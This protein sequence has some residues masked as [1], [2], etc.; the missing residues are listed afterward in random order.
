MQEVT[1]EAAQPAAVPTNIIGIEDFTKVEL[2]VGTIT[3]VD[4]LEKIR[5]SLYYYLR[6]LLG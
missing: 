3:K 2:V 6:S 5:T 1:Q 4:T